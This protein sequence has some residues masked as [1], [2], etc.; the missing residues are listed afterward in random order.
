VSGRRRAAVGSHVCDDLFQV[1]DAVLGV[2]AQMGH[3]RSQKRPLAPVLVFPNRPNRV[4]K[5]SP[6]PPAPK[7]PT[8]SIL[9]QIPFPKGLSG[10]TL[11]HLAIHLLLTTNPNRNLANH[12]AVVQ[13]GA[14]VTHLQG[15]PADSLAV[16]P[17]EAGSGAD[18]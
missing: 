13:L 10:A 5:R 3:S 14:A 15:K 16:D 4:P 17:S 11:V 7:Q 18:A 8:K 6:P 12:H 2:L 1:L 9:G